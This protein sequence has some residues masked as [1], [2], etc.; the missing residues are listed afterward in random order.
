VTTLRLLQRLQTAFPP[1]SRW[2]LG[3]DRGFPR[4]GLF[5]QLRQEGT[6]FSVRLRWRDWVTV[7]GV[8]AMVVEHWD[9]GRLVAGQQTAAAMGHGRP[10]QP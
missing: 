8:Y 3:A 4:A 1:G 7:A 5:A 9:A 6:G 2:R 10:E